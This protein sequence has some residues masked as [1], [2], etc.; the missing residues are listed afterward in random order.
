MYFIPSD[1]SFI[2]FALVHNCL[3][4]HKRE[5]IYL[6]IVFYLLGDVLT[7][8]YIIQSYSIQC[9][10][11]LVGDSRRSIYISIVSCLLKKKKENSTFFKKEFNFGSRLPDE[12]L[13][14]IFKHLSPSSILTCAQVCR[15]WTALTKERQVKF[16]Y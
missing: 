1:N 15:R 12:L 8:L 3:S 14:K 16:T 10:M 6:T 9:C 4:Y 7:L 2:S 11:T 13:L 5:I